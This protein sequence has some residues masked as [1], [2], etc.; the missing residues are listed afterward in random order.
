MKKP[1][2]P[3]WNNLD[4]MGETLSEM[5]KFMEEADYKNRHGRTTPLYKRLKEA[6]R[7]QREYHL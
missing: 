6:K 2:Q 4:E 7:D 5:I 1:K 3:Q